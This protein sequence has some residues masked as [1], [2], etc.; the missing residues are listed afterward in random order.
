[1]PEGEPSPRQTL[2]VLLGASTFRRAPKLA[3]GRAF[4]NS[5]QDFYEYLLASDGLDLPR[6]N[7][8]SLFD[9]SRSPSDQLQDLRDFL[10]SRSA[11]LKS[12]GTPPQD[13][14]VYYVGH[15]LFSGP[16]R[17]YCLA[18][19][20]TDE[21]S[22]GF[23]SIRVSDTASTI[24]AHARFL[25]KFLILDC[26]FSAQAYREFQSGPLQ[27]ARA[28]LLY[29]LPT[30]GTTLLCSAS[31]QDVSLAPVG[32]CRTMFSDCLLKALRQGH[33]SLGPRL[34]LNELGELVKV[35]L[36][37]AFPDKWVR[38][39]VESPDQREGDIANVHLFPNAAFKRKEAEEV[40]GRAEATPTQDDKAAQREALKEAE[41]KQSKI[42]GG[43]AGAE[44]AEVVRDAQEG[45]E[46]HRGTEAQAARQYTRSTDPAVAE[47]AEP[48]PVNFEL[49][50]A[51]SLSLKLVG[52]EVRTSVT[53]DVS[54]ENEIFD[55]FPTANAAPPAASDSIFL[56][57]EDVRGLAD[58]PIPI[59]VYVNSADQGD[60][61]KHPGLMVG[62]IFLRGLRKATLAHDTVTFSLEITSLFNSLYLAGLPPAV[63]RVRL[64]TQH[65]VSEE[66][67]IMIGRV[68]IT[69]RRRAESVRAEAAGAEASHGV[70]SETEGERPEVH[71]SAENG[72]P[73]APVVGH[74]GSPYGLILLIALF[75]SVGAVLFFLNGG[76]ALLDYNI[77]YA[78]TATSD[79]NTWPLGGCKVFH[80]SNQQGDDLAI[81]IRDA[82]QYNDAARLAR[83]YAKHFGV[84]IVLDTSYLLPT[85]DLVAKV[86]S[87]KPSRI[88]MCGPA[89]SY[90]IFKSVY[91][92]AFK[93]TSLSSV[94]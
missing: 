22:E 49:L 38:P 27:A 87:A 44:R 90:P 46:E 69:R 43:R 65:A 85:T 18:I 71:P 58:E 48:L 31:A 54:T 77:R 91:E 63:V 45:E 7:V 33:H 61:D 9:D 8:I 30:R 3:Q 57:L 36:Q 11:E 88:L 74:S 59:V 17:T 72:Q 75:V 41:E 80:V 51:N 84:R 70:F 83:Q 34:S 24:K 78:D 35:N 62:S 29:E 37:E 89:G 86:A 76:S 5:A 82:P 10:E 94:N 6:A 40:R 26:C 12:G 16:E 67:Q 21:R 28:K 39:Q 25:R 32:L 23:T 60:P 15:G 55:G 50:G 92:G 47:A 93:G 64:V 73:S 1:M 2:A 81:L 68:T 53:V 13:L 52:T 42:E 14:L 4:N 19:R 20:A 79:P 66:A 56:N